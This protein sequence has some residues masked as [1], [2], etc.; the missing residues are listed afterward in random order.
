MERLGH[1]LC[2]G[3]GVAGTAAGYLTVAAQHGGGLQAKFQHAQNM[4]EDIRRWWGRGICD[5][6]SS[7][8]EDVGHGRAAG[9]HDRGEGADP[10]RFLGC[11][12][13][14]ADCD[15][16]HRVQGPVLYA[17]ADAQEVGDVSVH[18]PAT[19]LEQL[20]RLPLGTGGGASAA[21]CRVALALAPPRPSAV[22]EV[23][24]ARLH[25]RDAGCKSKCVAFCVGQ[26]IREEKRFGRRRRQI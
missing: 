2:A 6:A 24:C 19:R 7:Q 13:L 16:G 5:A 8:D 21:F 3:P 14:A 17:S 18:A 10:P 20:L 26:T 15:V 1:G 23:A 12:A 25:T 22:C 9:V 4:D 11:A